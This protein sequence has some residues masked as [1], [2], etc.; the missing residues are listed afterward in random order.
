MW[1]VPLLSPMS[2]VNELATTI[3]PGAAMLA[4]WGSISERW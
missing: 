2:S 1:T 3:S 4:N